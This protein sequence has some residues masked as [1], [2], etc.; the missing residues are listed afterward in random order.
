MEI[1]QEGLGEF[2]SLTRFEVADDS[3]IRFWHDM[4]CGDQALKEAFPDL[5][6][7]ARIK[8]VYV[9]NHLDLSN[10]PHQWNVNFIRVAN[11]WEVDVFVSFFNCL[12]FFRL[13]RGGEDKL[14]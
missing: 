8:D 5:C 12:Y 9:A 4:W 11:N 13:R 1:H 3:K 10:G 14:C 6:S 7:I 2:A